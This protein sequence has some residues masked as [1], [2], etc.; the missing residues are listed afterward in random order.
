MRPIRFTGAFSSLAAEVAEALHLLTRSK[1]PQ[2][3]QSSSISLIPAFPYPI[4]VHGS[5]ALTPHAVLA[6]PSSA[7]DVAA[8]ALYSAYTQAAP[9][10]LNLSI[11][12]LLALLRSTLLFSSS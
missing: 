11:P 3:C 7:P 1:D 9:L 8:L 12:Q 10:E 2:G 5:G 4:A 6:Q